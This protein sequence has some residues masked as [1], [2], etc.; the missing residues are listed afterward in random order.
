MPSIDIELP[1]YVDDIHLGI[2]DCG[3]RCTG[4]EEE[5]DRDSEDELMNRAIVIIKEVGQEWNLPLESSNEERLIMRHRA[6]KKGLRNKKWV[7]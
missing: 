7:K 6:A 4:Q 5:E 2:Y 1:S 3:N